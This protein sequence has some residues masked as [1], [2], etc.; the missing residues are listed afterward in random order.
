MGRTVPSYRMILESEIKKWE[1]FLKA[2]RVEDRAAFEELMN[3][4]R[5]YASAAGAATRPIV[6]EAMFMS[7]LLSHQKSL[8]EMKVALERLK[9]AIKCKQ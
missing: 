3:E 9:S 4:C 8:R 7:I 6:A 2:L 1:G 5:R